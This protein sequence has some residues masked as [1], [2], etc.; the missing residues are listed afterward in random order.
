MKP[1]YTDT[2]VRIRSQ[3]I[4]IVII[5]YSICSGKLRSYMGDVTTD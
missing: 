1:T 3:V 5:I 2:D 4:K